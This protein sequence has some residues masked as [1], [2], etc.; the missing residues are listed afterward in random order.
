M[1]DNKIIIDPEPLQIKCYRLDPGE[2][3]LGNNTKVKVENN[4]ELDRQVQQQMFDQKALN[5]WAIYYGQRNQQT[6]EN[7]I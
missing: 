4:R 6:F 2:M 5:R 7:F 3:I 1:K